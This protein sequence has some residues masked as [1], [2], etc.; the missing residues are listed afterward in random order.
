MFYPE[1]RAVFMALIGWL[2][3]TPICPN[4]ETISLCSV[5]AIEKPASNNSNEPTF[6][7]YN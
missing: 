3:F 5:G 4:T 7:T 6:S 2:R 1:A